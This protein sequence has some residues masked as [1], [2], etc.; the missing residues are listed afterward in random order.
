MKRYVD[1]CHQMDDKNGYRIILATFVSNKFCSK[2]NWVRGIEINKKNTVCYV[3]FLWDKDMSYFLLQDEDT[4]KYY[5]L[6]QIR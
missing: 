5:K 1:L 2:N 6:I 4:G 3:K